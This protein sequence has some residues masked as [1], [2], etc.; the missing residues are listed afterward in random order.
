MPNKIRCSYCGKFISYDDL[1]SGK[2]KCS[3]VPDSSFGPEEIDFVCKKC[4]EEK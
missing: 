3:F 2:A 1:D 4:T